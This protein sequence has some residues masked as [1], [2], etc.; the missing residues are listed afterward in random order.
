MAAVLRLA[1]NCQYE[2]EHAHQDA[3]L[4]LRLFDELQALHR[5]G[6]KEREW[7][8][9]AAILHDIGWIQDRRGHH[10]RARDMVMNTTEIPFDPMER[11]MV[12]LVVRYHRR[13]L[14]KPT[15][16]YFSNL[17]TKS[18]ETVGQLAS[19]LRIA[20]GLDRRHICA[21]KDLHCEI[22]AQKI[23]VKIEA[24][25][26]SQ[27]ERTAAKKKADLFEKVFGRELLI[28]GPLH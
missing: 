26:F 16:R 7:L 15:H 17:D 25:D 9:Y 23:I 19:F 20:D 8:E 22:Q 24:D 1:E 28:E 11:M 12:A 4:A 2:K 6:C 5:L 14:P 21:V 3:K 27:M 13:S 10:K 18:Q